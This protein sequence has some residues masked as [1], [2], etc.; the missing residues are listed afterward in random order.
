MVG[1]GPETGPAVAKAV[2]GAARRPRLRAEMK[3]AY[4]LQVGRLAILACRLCRSDVVSE[5]SVR[6]PFRP[7]ALLRRLSSISATDFYADHPEGG[8]RRDLHRVEDWYT[9]C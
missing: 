5:P 9:H 2:S 4:P 8:A 7:A 6:T 3:A 1:G